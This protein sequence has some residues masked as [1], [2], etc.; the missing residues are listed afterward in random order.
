MNLADVAQEL[1][2][3]PLAQFVPSRDAH[4]ARLRTEGDRDLARAVGALRRPTTA[5]WAMN[6]LTRAQADELDQLV[7]LG[8]ALRDAQSALDGAELRD[9]NRTR[10][11]LVAALRGQVERLAADA[12]QRLSE[13]VARQVESTLH[14]VMADDV[15]AAAVRTGLLTRELESTGLEPVDV[16][17]AVA[18]PDAVAD[19]SA[20]PAKAGPN[21]KPSTG[22]TG[23]A[24][25]KRKADAKADARAD[26]KAEAARR[27]E[28]R[29]EEEARA[30]ARAQRDRA[31]ADL[32]T[33]TADAE[34]AGR[35]AADLAAR[36]AAAHA[37]L[38]DLRATLR[39]AEAGADDLATGLERAR[40]AESSAAE[41]LAA[42][43]RAAD[44]ARDVVDRLTG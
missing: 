18:L 4:A 43:Q 31:E 34:D 1:Y 20:K 42:A 12:G 30:A 39:Q 9:L 36:S 7:A 19:R 16:A 25:A 8:G 13:P 32:A 26:A 3:L 10:H 44:R 17:G 27:A 35:A 15:A 38:E 21:T 28:E 33:A 22:R 14:A 6:L 29:A 24:D 41:R 37:R 40:A 11:R 23:E 5:A 2:G